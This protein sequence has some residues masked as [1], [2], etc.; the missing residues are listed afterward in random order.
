MSNAVIRKLLEQRLNTITPALETVFENMP[1]TPKLG[2]PWQQV[3][4]L[5]APTANPT[6]GSPHHREVGEFQVSLN[7][8]PMAGSQA[9]SSRV[10]LIRQT[11]YRGLTMEEGTLRVLI[12][13]TPYQLR[14]QQ[15]P[16]WYFVAVAVPFIADVFVN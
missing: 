1:Y 11:F 9:S 3:H 16:N 6:M 7:Y 13:G 12:D 14:S 5:F 10:Q 4:L 15:L 8:P 2:T